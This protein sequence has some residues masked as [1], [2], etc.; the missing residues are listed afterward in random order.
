MVD[1]SVLPA[2]GLSVQELRTQSRNEE[3]QR[4][5]GWELAVDF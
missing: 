4:V 5:L 1:S 2:R 3:T